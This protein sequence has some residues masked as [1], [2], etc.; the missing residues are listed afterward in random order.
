MIARR[1]HW[2]AFTGPIG[3]SIEGDK[4]CGGDIGHSESCQSGS[5]V[6]DVE[7]NLFNSDFA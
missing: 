1:I 7:G 2:W 5:D 3:G 6:S 4:L